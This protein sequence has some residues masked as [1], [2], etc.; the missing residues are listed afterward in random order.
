M[1]KGAK[2]MHQTKLRSNHH[3]LTFKA[4]KEQAVRLGALKSKHDDILKRHLMG[5]DM[6]A[7]NP[8]LVAVIREEFEQ[9]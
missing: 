8:D 2:I 9:A 3:R 1:S 4:Y 6:E 5:N 7:A